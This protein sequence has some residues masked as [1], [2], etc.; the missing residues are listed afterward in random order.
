MK[1]GRLGTLLTV[2]ARPAESAR[3]A[4]LIFR[5]TSSL[6]IRVREE[7]RFVLPRHRVTVA[8]PWGE[9]RIKIAQLDSEHDQAAPEYEDCRRLAEQHAIPLKRVIEEALRAFKQSSPLEAAKHA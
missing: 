8:T 7:K 4:S 3:L 9:V 2:L 5:E 6:G 1:K